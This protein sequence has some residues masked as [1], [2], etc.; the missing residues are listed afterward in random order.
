MIYNILAL[1]RHDPL[2]KIDY[3]NMDDTVV[4]RLNDGPVENSVFNEELRLTDDIFEDTKLIMKNFLSTVCIVCWIIN[5]IFLRFYISNEYF[6]F[7]LSRNKCQR[8]MEKQS[9]RY[10]LL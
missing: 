8:F 7:R 2:E 5:Y 6:H 9:G 1:G 3:F 4:N 10:M